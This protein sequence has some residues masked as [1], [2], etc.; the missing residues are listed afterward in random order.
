MASYG[1]QTYTHKTTG[2]LMAVSDDL[3]GFVVHAH[4]EE[5]LEDKLASVFEA[6]MRATDRP[7]KNVTVIK[8]EPAPG[9]GPP[10]FVANAMPDTA[11][12]A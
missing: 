7:V 2:L 9:F 10:H 4:S 11:E 12:A 8:N 5:E 6:F 1:I 3:P